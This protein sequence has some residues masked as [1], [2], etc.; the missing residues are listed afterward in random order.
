MGY[1]IKHGLI[2]VDK[3]VERMTGL[4]ER[5]LAKAQR[6]IEHYDMR[7]TYERAMLGQSGGIATDQVKPEAGGA[8]KCLFSPRGGWSYVVKVNKVTV[9]IHDPCNYGGGVWK[10]NI[11]F[12]KIKAVLS[13]DQVEVLRDTGMLRDVESATGFVTV[14]GENSQAAE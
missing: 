1:A 2:G 12:D 9:T 8:I 4:Y 6:W 11:P 13:K 7:L 14:T 10:R 3:A 5:S